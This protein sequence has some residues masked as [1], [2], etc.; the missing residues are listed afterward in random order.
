MGL[1]FTTSFRVVRSFT[2]IILYTVFDVI[3]IGKINE[4]LHLFLCNIYIDFDVEICYNIMGSRER[5]K[6]L[7]PQ[8]R[9]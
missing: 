5:Y 1:S 3:S 6:N 2:V 9:T 8:E 7:L 4:V